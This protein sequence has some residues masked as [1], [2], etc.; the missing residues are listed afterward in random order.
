MIIL[1]LFL[2]FMILINLLIS[3]GFSLYKKDIVGCS[4][5]VL[6]F[7]TVLSIEHIKL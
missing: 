6:V 3:S 7:F 5:I 2:G 4:F 1:V